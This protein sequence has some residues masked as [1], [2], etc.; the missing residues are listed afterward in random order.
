MEKATDNAKQGSPTVEN[1]AVQDPNAEPQE[2]TAE[3]LKQAV[4]ALTEKD[5]KSQ[6]ELKRLQGVL[7]SQGVT[8]Q[9][10]VDLR[11]EVT[12]TQDLLAE[13]MDTI[14]QGGVGELNDTPKTSYS[15]KLKA[16]R[17]ASQSQVNSDPDAQM[18]F[19]YMISQ[20]LN[21]ESAEVKEALSDGRTPQE[22]FTHLKGSIDAKSEAT[23]RTETAEAVQ[24]ALK[25]AGLTGGGVNAPTAGGKTY[26][27]EGIRNMSDEDYLEQKPAID[28]AIAAGL[29]K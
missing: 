6:Q 20:G 5:T 26:T 10:L 18:F 15:E 24:A 25:L 12:S 27:R 28:A 22:A 11:Q 2:P 7:K 14:N 1:A 8:K 23:R 29:V 4:L 13:A 9:D 16:A 3:E 21:L 17:Q 19:G